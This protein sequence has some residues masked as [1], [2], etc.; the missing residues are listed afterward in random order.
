MVQPS[1]AS[2]VRAPSNKPQN[3]FANF[4]DKIEHYVAL[5]SG[6]A[7]ERFPQATPIT[8][9]VNPDIV[10]DSVFKVHDSLTSRAEIADLASVFKDEVIAII[11]LGGTGSYVLDFMVKTRVKEVRSFRR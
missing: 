3:G 7:I 2:H 9:R 11:G 5:I 8:F 10:P 4:F 1:A 6:P